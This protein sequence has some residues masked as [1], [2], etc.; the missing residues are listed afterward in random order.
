LFALREGDVRAR[1][2]GENPGVELDELKA[3][4][5]AEIAKSSAL[6]IGDLA[7]GGAD[8]MEVLGVPPGRVI[9]DVLRRLLE[10]VLDDDSL[11]DKATL[12]AMIPAAAAEAG[13]PGAKA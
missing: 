7:V 10:R 8:V 2:H 4:I 13:V 9:G 6:S 5:A 1:G 12:R 3:R 11:N